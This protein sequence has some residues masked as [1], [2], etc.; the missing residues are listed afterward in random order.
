MLEQLNNVF[1]LGKNGCFIGGGGLNFVT[2]K[3]ENF[4]QFF[5]TLV[6]DFDVLALLEYVAQ[7]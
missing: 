7:S 6:T 4:R 3:S 2:K 1:Y 5:C